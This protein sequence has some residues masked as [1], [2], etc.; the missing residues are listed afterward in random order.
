VSVNG[1]S[2]LTSK[3]RKAIGAMMAGHNFEDVALQANVS[4]TTIY[5]WQDHPAF[6]AELRRLQRLAAMGH[7]IA[8]TAE[9]TR[10][11]AVLVGARDDIEAPWAIRVRAAQA[12]EDALFRWVDVVIISERLEALEALADAPGQ[13]A[14][15]SIGWDDG[16]IR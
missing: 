4:V 11:R 16:G 14:G 9:L 3:Q 7:T 1:N 12:L 6:A 13:P 15:G 5:R 2:E 10:N 8:L